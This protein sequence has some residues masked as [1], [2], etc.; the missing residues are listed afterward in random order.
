MTTK[1][2]KAALCLRELTDWL[3]RVMTAGS[4]G[5]ECGLNVSVFRQVTALQATWSPQLPFALDQPTSLNKTTYRAPK[6]PPPPHHLSYFGEILF[7]LHK[8]LF[9][10]LRMSL[11]LL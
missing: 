7:L 8:F 4:L 10:I 11:W 9:V 1:Y 2:L 3:G 5:L 6:L